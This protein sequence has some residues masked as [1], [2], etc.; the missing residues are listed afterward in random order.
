MSHR[1]P[2]GPPGQRSGN[3]QESGP[4]RG[5]AGEGTGA[6]PKRRYPGLTNLRQ[7]PSRSDPF[8]DLTPPSFASKG[9]KD[10]LHENRRPGD[11]IPEVPEHAPKS[12]IAGF[13]LR[14]SLHVSKWPGVIWYNA[15][16]NRKKGTMDVVARTV[17]HKVAL[18]SFKRG[19]HHERRAMEKLNH[20]YIL[21]C[22][23]W[24]VHMDRHGEPEQ[25]AAIFPKCGEDLKSQV[26]K[27]KVGSFKFQWPFKIPPGSQ[28]QALPMQKVQLYMSQVAQALA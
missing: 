12:K 5:R 17:N 13:Q 16:I 7:Y 27:V 21:I 10:P 18:E 9:P 22:I 15:V 2:S 28:R 26:R 8:Q 4:S 14:E 25:S 6:K 3:G 23:D 11:P 24:M 1:T 20:E 19:I